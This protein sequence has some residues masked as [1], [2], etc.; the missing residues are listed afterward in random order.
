MDR[1]TV[2]TICIHNWTLI[3]PRA[4]R[5]CACGICHKLAA[6]PYDSRVD[7][8]INPVS[9]IEPRA[10]LIGCSVFVTSIAKCFVCH[11]HGHDT[12]IPKTLV[13][14]NHVFIQ[15][16]TVKVWISPVEI[17]LSIIVNKHGG[18]DP[19][20]SR[21]NQIGSQ[22]IFKR[23]CGRVGYRHTYAPGSALDTD[24]RIHIILPVSLNNLLGPGSSI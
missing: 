18:I 9:L 21:I 22:G 8:V 1:V 13:I 12:I 24:W 16:C 6:I 5:A 3:F 2:Q 19:F 15:L 14:R 7:H 4:N 20:P 17:R 11:V 23:P 10:L